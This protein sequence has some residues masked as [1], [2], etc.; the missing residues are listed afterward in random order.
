MNR[1]WSLGLTQAEGGESVG[2]F[3]VVL[4]PFKTRQPNVPNHSTSHLLSSLFD[5]EVTVCFF[6][7]YNVAAELHS[8]SDVKPQTVASFRRCIILHFDRLRDSVVDARSDV[9]SRCTLRR[10]QADRLRMFLEYCARSLDQED[11]A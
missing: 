5:G 4:V 1:I 6:V 9:T 8:L 10:F 3:H 7:L 11:H 2:G